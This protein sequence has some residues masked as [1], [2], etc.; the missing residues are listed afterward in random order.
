MITKQ[1]HCGAA[2]EAKSTLPSWLNSASS[3]PTRKRLGPMA[4]RSRISAPTTA[5][6]PICTPANQKGSENSAN[7]MPPAGGRGAARPGGAERQESIGHGR[8]KLWVGH[9]LMH[10]FPPRPR[11]RAYLFLSL[12]LCFIPAFGP[13]HSSPLVI[14]SCRTVMC[15]VCIAPSPLASAETVHTATKAFQ[16]TAKAPVNPVSMVRPLGGMMTSRRLGLLSR[17]T[18]LPG[19]AAQEGGGARGTREE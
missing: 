4:K 5:C 3:W 13:I 6:R 8:R 16:A 2:P 11:L 7:R 9:S 12:A 15:A 17:I 14:I 1:H 19:G 18:R 10:L